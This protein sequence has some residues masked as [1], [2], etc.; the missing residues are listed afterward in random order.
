MDLKLEFIIKTQ[1]I[2]IASVI[3]PFYSQSAEKL[4]F[5]N[6]FCF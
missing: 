6:H 1:H 5:S 3:I 2:A 4:E